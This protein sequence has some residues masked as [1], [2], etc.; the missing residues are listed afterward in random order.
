MAF[1]TS[2]AISNRLRVVA[3]PDARVKSRPSSDDTV[4]LNTVMF[5]RKTECNFATET[6]G[7][8]RNS[9]GSLGVM[10]YVQHGSR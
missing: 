3:S 2:N 9:R 7:R 10:H 1:H 6:T 5:G 4:V 8:T